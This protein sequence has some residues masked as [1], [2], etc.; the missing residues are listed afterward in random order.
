MLKSDNGLA[1]PPSHG[2]ALRGIVMRAT[3]QAVPNLTNLLATN[4]P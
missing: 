2:A 3:P 4:V 1:R